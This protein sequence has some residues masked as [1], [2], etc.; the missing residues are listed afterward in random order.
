MT[1][2]ATIRFAAAMT[3]GCALIAVLAS[4][5]TPRQETPPA[6]T[7]DLSGMQL[8]KQTQGERYTQCVPFARDYSG[9]QIFGD[10]WTWWSQANG[11]YARGQMPQRGSVL[12]LKK[13]NKLTAGHVAVVPALR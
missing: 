4:C 10:A 6:S 1:R 2:Q 7:M 9:I 11:R 8:A 13:T 3:I 12:T 5:T